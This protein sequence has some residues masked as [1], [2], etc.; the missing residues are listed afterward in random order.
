MLVAAYS[1]HSPMTLSPHKAKT[2]AVSHEGCKLTLQQKEKQ[3]KIIKHYAC[4]T[5]NF[6]H[7]LRRCC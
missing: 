2:T 7:Y 3:N 5:K 4:Y 6:S 1:K